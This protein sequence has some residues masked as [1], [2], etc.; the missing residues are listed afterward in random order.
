MRKSWKNKLL[1]LLVLL[2]PFSFTGCNEAGDGAEA[3]NDIQYTCP[4]HPQIVRDEPG[5][6]P[7]C[8]M[9][10]VAKQTADAPAIAISSDLE[11]LLQPANQAV[12]SG[13]ETA[14]PVQKQVQQ[15]ITM[16]GVVT[17]D[18]RRQYIIPAR[19]GG[20]I[21]KLYVQFNFQPI[22]KGQKLYDIYSPELVTAQKEL[23]YLLENDPSNSSL[24]NGAKQKLRLLGATAGQVEQLIRSGRETYTFSVYSPYSGYVLDPA[25]AASPSPVAT[26][27]PAAPATGGGG[28]GGMGGG[29]TGTGSSASPPIPSGGFSIREG[30]YVSTG[31]ALLKVID[32]SQV[33]AQFNMPSS[34]AG[35][36]KKGTPISITFNQLPDKT[37]QSEVNLVEPV[38]EAGENFAQVRASLPAGNTSTLIGQLIT[39]KVTYNTGMSLW[40]P[41]EAVLD[42]GTQSVAFLNNNGGFKP[43]SVR[44]GGSADGMVEILSG[45]SAQD[46]IAVNAQFLVDSESFIRVADNNR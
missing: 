23:L 25:V 20:R 42:I 15:E 3:A 13:I 30:M 40:V 32:A 45:L 34:Q 11:Y 43:I 44:I 1:W 27:T 2:L 18:T 39:G 4:M 37:V 33:W 21:E 41:K 12:V 36:L 35:Q 9:D 16:S 38:Y 22:R 10:L 29:A 19:F 28:M 6:C 8:G 5:S 31:Q 7:I 14:Q 24:I 17:Y 46:T 26:A